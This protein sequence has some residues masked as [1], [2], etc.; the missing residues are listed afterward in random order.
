MNIRVGYDRYR[1]E[2]DGWS[3]LF[4]DGGA[5]PCGEQVEHL[6][7]ALSAKTAA[8]DRWRACCVPVDRG[9]GK[10]TWPDLD[11]LGAECDRHD[12]EA[13]SR[14]PVDDPTKARPAPVRRDPNRLVRIRL[15]PDLYERDSYGWARLH[16]DA[17]VVRS[18]CDPA[19]HRL[20]DELTAERERLGAAATILR[21]RHID[22]YHRQNV[23]HFLARY[24]ARLGE[25]RG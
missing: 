15:G 6:L 13:K 19:A 4:D 18:T 16:D 7:D 22:K 21:T 9:D 25:A 3:K 2:E 5:S 11:A 12:A 23:A 8:C 14:A 17:G 1:K 10:R 20:L 24:D